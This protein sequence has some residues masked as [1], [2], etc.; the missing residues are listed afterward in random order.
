MILLYLEARAGK[1]WS[2]TDIVHPRIMRPGFFLDNFE[3]FIGSITVA[4][5]ANGLKPDITLGVIV[6]R[7]G[8]NCV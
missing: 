1:G 5:M 4:V 3:G 6:S 7:L 2:A 8:V